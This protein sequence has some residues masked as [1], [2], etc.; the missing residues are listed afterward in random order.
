MGGGIPDTSRM[1]IDVVANEFLGGSRRRPAIAR[2]TSAAR[3]CPLSQVEQSRAALTTGVPEVV[4][5]LSVGL[6]SAQ[7]NPSDNDGRVY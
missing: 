5:V 4:V 7:T 1:S 3:T 6:A 2:T